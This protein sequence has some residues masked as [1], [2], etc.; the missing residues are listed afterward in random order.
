MTMN[1][2]QVGTKKLKFAELP[3]DTKELLKNL[4]IEKRRA[5]SHR[6]NEAGWTYASIGR[7]IGISR[8]AVEQQILHVK[9]N[10]LEETM[11]KE[12]SELPVPEQPTKPI[13]KAVRKEVSPDVLVQLK[14]LHDKAKLVRGKGQ[15]F[16]DEAEEFTKLA[17]EQVQNGV[18]VYS[19]A[20][21]LG[22]T[23]GAIFFR[24]VR[25][26]YADPKTGKSKVYKKLT[27]RKK[28][29]GNA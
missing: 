22:I 20:K 16:R 10:P 3:S 29:E 15:Q 19:L 14:E 11:A 5:Y 7:A 21:S 1:Q 28:V 25:Y 23:H 12:V 27:H 26:G 6:L 2:A 24:F 4:P 18:S 8:Q 13:Y 9:R 17:W